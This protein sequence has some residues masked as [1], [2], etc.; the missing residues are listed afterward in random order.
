MAPILRGPNWSL[1]FHISTD[2]SNIS[3]GGVLG[4]KENQQNYAIYFTSKNLT[5]PELNYIVT[6][7]EF[8]AVVH[9][10]NK[11]R[12]YITGY[13]VFVHT[14][15]S[16]IRFF[17]N[18]PVTTGRITRCLLLLQEFNITIVDQPG[19]ENLV[20]DFLSRIPQDSSD[21]L[22]NDNFPNEHMFAVAVKTPWFAD[23]ENYLATGRLPAHLSPPQKKRI[24]QQSAYYSWV[25]SDIFYTSPDM[26]IRRCVREDEIPN[27][28]QVC[29][30]GPCRGH[31]SDKRMAYKVLQSGYYWSTFFKDATKYVRSCD[32][33][34]RMGRPTIVDEI[35]L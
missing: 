31:F 29:H 14:D 1:P 11:F 27:I 13:E 17:M 25:G 23:I 6:E 33:C 30:D 10:I 32:S 22:V 9:A 35:P 24:V 8:L 21:I 20:A 2:A 28:L 16:D 7:K 26:I 15:H 12:H 18:K 5:P 4:Q 19:K 34:Q 3:L